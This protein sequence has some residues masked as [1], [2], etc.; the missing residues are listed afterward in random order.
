[1][2]FSSPEFI[3][4]FLPAAVC[5]FFVISRWQVK[6]LAIAWLVLASLFFYGWWR[7]D[8]VPLLLASIIVNYGLGVRLAETR[9]Q[10]LLILG[11]AGNLLLLGYFKYTSFALDNVNAVFGS[12][13]STLRLLLPL[14]ISFWTFQQIAFLVDAYGGVTRERRFLN[15]CLFVSFFPQLIAGPIVHHK[16]MLPQFDQPDAF[17]PN[18]DKIIA[19]LTV[20]VM[21][22]F[23]KVVIAD[24]IGVY[25]DRAFDAA[26]DGKVLTIAEAWSGSVMFAFQLYFDFSGYADMAIGIGLLFGI[27]LPINFDSPFKAASIIEFWQ[28]FHM[29][30]TRFLTAYVYNPVVLNLTRRRVASGKGILR[31][32]APEI[33]P[34]IALV[35]IPTLFT[36]FLSG[37]WHGAGWQF[38]IF[39]VLHGAYLVINHAWRFLRHVV[40]Y[41]TSPMPWLTRPVGILVTFAAVVIANIFFRS[42]SAG[43]GWSMLVSFFG[44]NGLV[45]PRAFSSVLGWINELSPGT[46]TFRTSSVLLIEQIYWVPLLLVVTWFLPNTQRWVAGVGLDHGRSAERPESAIGTGRLL[47]RPSVAHG[48]FVGGV[49]YFAVIEVISNP[50]NQFIYFDF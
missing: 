6:Q 23:K 40:G 35:A 39:G 3:T 15:Y 8:Y 46:I 14:G 19:G 31:P 36:M 44:L 43:Q 18:L 27:A 20:F 10:P 13:F 28:R 17:R 42:E 5:G 50:P 11:I 25:A 45:V 2:L 34:F 48:I 1:M 12:D 9:S 16:E 49:L 32:N 41:K 33:R 30:L 24:N 37:I 26:A 29:T 7:P 47:W 4:W 22:L 38:I 21:G